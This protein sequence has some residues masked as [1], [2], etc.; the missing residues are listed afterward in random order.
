MR[1]HNRFDQLAYEPPVPQELS[2]EGVLAALDRAPEH[3]RAVIILTDVKDFS[4]KEVAETLGVPIGTVMLRLTAAAS[5]CVRRSPVWPRATDP[6][7]R[8]RPCWRRPETGIFSLTGVIKPE[9][10]NLCR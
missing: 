5:C 6:A 1:R 4:Y 3:F 9:R 8:R 10:R 7:R 2:D